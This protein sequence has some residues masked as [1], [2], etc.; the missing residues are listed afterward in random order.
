MKTELELAVLV[1]ADEMDNPALSD[2]QTYIGCVNNPTA[3]GVVFGGPHRNQDRKAYLFS[4]VSRGR[5]MCAA[6]S[7]GTVSSRR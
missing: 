7:D 5:V 6:L 1:A 4:I 2:F 3:D